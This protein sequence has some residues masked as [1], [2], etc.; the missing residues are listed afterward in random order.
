M[1][2]V[3]E[4]KEFAA[5][6]VSGVLGG[7]V[8]AEVV[9]RLLPSRDRALQREEEFTKHLMDQVH[10]LAETVIGAEVKYRQ[11]L[12]EIQENADV[13]LASLRKENDELRVEI[14][15]LRDEPREG[16]P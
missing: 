7:G 6:L 3:M 12:R 13:R 4:G 11:T 10:A 1:K 5:A 9:R 16:R 2:D 15:R 8:L 14:D